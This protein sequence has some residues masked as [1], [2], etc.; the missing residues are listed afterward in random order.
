MS[1]RSFRKRPLTQNEDHAAG[2]DIAKVGVSA[3][4]ICLACARKLTSLH[5]FNHTESLAP[6]GSGFICGSTDPDAT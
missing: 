3:I 1:C 6:R 2:V 5:P 4:S